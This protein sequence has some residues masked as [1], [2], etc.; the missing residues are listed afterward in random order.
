MKESPSSVNPEKT[1]IN[2]EI[3]LQSLKEF[4]K[5]LKKLYKQR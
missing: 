1:I 5:R 3:N 2:F 4:G